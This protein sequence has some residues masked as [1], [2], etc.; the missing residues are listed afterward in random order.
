[1]PVEQKLIMDKIN[2]MSNLIDLSVEKVQRIS[3]ELRPGLLDDLGLI[4][5]LKWEIEEFTTDLESPGTPS[6]VSNLKPKHIK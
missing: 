3:G 6:Y 4:A 1:M 2:S 5:A